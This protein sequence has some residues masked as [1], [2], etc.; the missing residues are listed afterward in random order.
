MT[1]PIEILCLIGGIIL[2]LIGIIYKIYVGRLSLQEKKLDEFILK[3]E[4]DFLKQIKEIDANTAKK[5][6]EIHSDIDI[7]YNSQHADIKDLYDK[8]HAF[9]KEITAK[10]HD[11]EL[12]VTEFGS[13]YLTRNEYNQTQKKS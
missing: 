3:T 4:N 1:I 8:H 2:A 7:K 6:L 11:I 10:T 9:E 5:I 12:S 13:I